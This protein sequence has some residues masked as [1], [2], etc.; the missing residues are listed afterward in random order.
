M[1]LSIIHLAVTKQDLEFQTLAV[2]N[3]DLDHLTSFPAFEPS[4]SGD[5]MDSAAESNLDSSLKMAL[6]ALNQ[7]DEGVQ[8]ESAS[9]PPS[10]PD[11]GTTTPRLRICACPPRLWSFIPP[12]NY[13][14]VDH[15]A[16]FRSSYP[17]DRNID[18]V[19]SLRI[20]SILYGPFL[21]CSI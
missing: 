14:V 10:P 7:K 13:G 1:C 3:G 11:S 20:R 19:R 17:Q 15:N 16:V 5:R 12:P 4:K 21:C 6:S 8:V 9:R 2:M 18:F